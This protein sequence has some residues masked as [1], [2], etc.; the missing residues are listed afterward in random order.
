MPAACAAAKTLIGQC[1]VAIESFRIAG[2]KSMFAGKH[3]GWAQNSPV[4]A[5]VGPGALRFQG[6]NWGQRTFLLTIC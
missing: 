6:K 5:A 1:D 2:V 4:I 3:D